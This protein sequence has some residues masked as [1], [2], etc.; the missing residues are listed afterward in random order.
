MQNKEGRMTKLLAVRFEVSRST[1]FKTGC[2]TVKR[3]PGLTTLK[4]NFVDLY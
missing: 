1:T 2:C 3:A 4:L